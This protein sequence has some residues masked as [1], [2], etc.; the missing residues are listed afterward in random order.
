MAFAGLDTYGLKDWVIE[1]YKRDAELYD[2]ALR[3]KDELRVNEKRNKS[4]NNDDDELLLK[5]RYWRKRYE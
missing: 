5:I 1:L 3:E 2:K 4:K